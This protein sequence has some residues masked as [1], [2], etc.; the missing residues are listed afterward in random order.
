[1]SMATPATFSPGSEEE[2]KSAE[3]TRGLST[4]QLSRPKEP[5]V[6]EAV[7]SYSKAFPSRDR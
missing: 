6:F 2:L 1:M 7:K 4:F 5:D 3:T